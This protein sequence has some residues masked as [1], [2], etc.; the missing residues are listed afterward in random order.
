MTPTLDAGFCGRL[1]YAITASLLSARSAELKGFWCDGVVVEMP[2]T[3]VALV[4]FDRSLELH[5]LAWTGRTGQEEYRLTLRFT[6]ASH[7][8]CRR[9]EDLKPFLPDATSDRWLY[10]HPPSRRIVVWLS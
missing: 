10:V 3:D 4:E 9:G 6:A 2:T 5:G 1:E 8:A 7:R